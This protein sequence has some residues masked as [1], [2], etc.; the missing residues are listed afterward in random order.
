MRLLRLITAGSVDDGKSTLIGRLLYDSGALLDDHVE[1]LTDKRSGDIIFANATDGLKAEREQGITIDVAHRTL[2]TNRIRFFI[3]DCPGHLE[4]LRNMVTAASTADLAV[5][6]VDV[7][8]G[9]SEQTKRHAHIASLFGAAEIILCVNKMDL[10]NHS[11]DA[12]EQVAY[13]FGQFA[14]SSGIRHFSLIPTSALLGENIVHRSGKMNWYQG[15]TLLEQLES[16]E[17][18]SQFSVESPFRFSVQLVLC[19]DA[20]TRLYAGKILSGVAA[21]GQL[22]KVLPSGRTTRISAIFKDCTTVSTARATESVSLSLQDDI[23]VGRGDLIADENHSATD[24]FDATVSW[25]ANDSL[26]S[27]RVLRLKHLQKV[28]RVRVSDI[29]SVVRLTDGACIEAKQVPAN[30]V[31]K[32][33]LVS[34]EPLVLDP[35][36]QVRE[37]GG[38]ILI[39]DENNIVG[40][41]LVAS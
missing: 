39:D 28:T 3:S 7:R 13:E 32:V 19:G 12:F 2:S 8:N 24:R 15:P 29:H 6:I 37:S 11:L 34:A 5:L 30:G 23:D 10:V 25:L 36:S 16:S 38:F 41:G 4:Y 31:G 26:S 14:G 22:V 33:S 1:N 35:Y 9:M 21:P 18:N 40:A 17:A 27:G 20:R